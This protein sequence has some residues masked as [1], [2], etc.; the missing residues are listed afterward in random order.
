MPQDSNSNMIKI[1]NFA[2]N[3]TQLKRP[4]PSHL[5]SPH[6]QFQIKRISE[7][8]KSS[9]QN[10][11]YVEIELKRKGD[12]RQKMLGKDTEET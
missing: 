11:N 7:G 9:V 6:K 10:Y 1:S 5:S 4:S 3:I 12:S 2:S 8:R